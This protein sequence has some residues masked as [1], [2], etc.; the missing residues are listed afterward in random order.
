M[1]PRLKRLARRLAVAFVAIVVLILT[2]FGL[3]L[4]AIETPWGKD[5]IRAFIVRQAND[6][7][8]ATLEIGDLTGSLLRGVELS[9]IRLSREGETIVSITAVNVSYTIR[10]LMQP[11]LVIRSIRLIRPFVVAR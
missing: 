1:V 2:L 6:Y 7:L 5:Q 3:V 10:E 9:D 8:T 11:G 4:F